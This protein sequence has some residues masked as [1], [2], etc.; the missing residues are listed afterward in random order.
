MQSYGHLFPPLSQPRRGGM[1]EGRYRP[2]SSTQ[3]VPTGLKEEGDSG[4]AL[5]CKHAAPTKLKTQ[6]LVTFQKVFDLLIFNLRVCAA[7]IG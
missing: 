1:C 3:A 7:K 6:A 5:C 2:R 4:A